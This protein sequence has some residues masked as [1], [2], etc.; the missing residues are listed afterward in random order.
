MVPVRVAVRRRDAHDS[1]AA[2]QPHDQVLALAW[3]RA[4]LLFYT[5]IGCHWLSFHRDLPTN[6][7]VI[8]VIFSQNDSGALGDARP[9]GSA[10]PRV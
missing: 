2:V 6:L 3:P 8:A 10:A 1:T 5:V 7:A 4:T 9:R